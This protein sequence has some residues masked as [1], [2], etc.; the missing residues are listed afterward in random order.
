[1]LGRI[2]SQ[3]KSSQASETGLSQVYFFDL[4][5][6]VLPRPHQQ[7]IR[8]LFKVQQNPYVIKRFRAKIVIRRG[9]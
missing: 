3:S 9:N 1:M 4:G 6:P 7:F 2:T 8:Q 5:Y